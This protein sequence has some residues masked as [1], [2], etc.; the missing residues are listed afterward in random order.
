MLTTTLLLAVITV[1]IDADF[2]DYEDGIT[3]SQKSDSIS[4]RSPSIGNEPRRRT[5]KTE[6]HQQTVQRPVHRNAVHTRKHISEEEMADFLAFQTVHPR[7]SRQRKKEAFITSFTVG[8]CVPRRLA[9]VH[10]DTTNNIVP[11]DASI[12]D[13]F[14]RAAPLASGLND[15]PTGW[16]L[17]KP[18]DYEFRSNYRQ[19][20]ANDF[21]NIRPPNVN[22]P[23]D[24]FAH[25]PYVYPQQ[26]PTSQANYGN[27]YNGYYFRYQYFPVLIPQVSVFYW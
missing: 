23:I 19:M 9:N 24:N 1:R 11:S 8:K 14:P 3:G 16:N 15:V 4:S 25:N 10:P 2:S 18:S 6:R 5:H 21:G 7:E 13:D 20:P 12:D 27:Y 22:N 17:N 26:Y